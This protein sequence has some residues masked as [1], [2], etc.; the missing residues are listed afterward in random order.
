MYEI[1]LAETMSEILSIIIKLCSID[2]KILLLI[3]SKLASNLKK[4]FFR[5][6]F[7]FICDFNLY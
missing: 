3:I 4:V 6:K 7:E 1:N 5:Y 2:F